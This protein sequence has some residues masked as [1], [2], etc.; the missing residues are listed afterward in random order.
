MQ[1]GLDSVKEN[2][3]A[4]RNRFKMSENLSVNVKYIQYFKHQIFFFHFDS[5]EPLVSSFVYNEKGQ[6]KVL[7]FPPPS[8]SEESGVSLSLQ[9][10][11]QPSDNISKE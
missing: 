2:V 11:L 10:F 8:Q 1:H 7:V 4:K 5:K 9:A 3:S 6:K